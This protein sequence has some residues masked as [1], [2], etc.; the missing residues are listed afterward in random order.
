VSGKSKIHIVT[1]GCPKNQVDSEVLQAQLQL[2]SGNVEV[3]GDTDNADTIVINTCGFIQDAKRESIDAI[4]EAIEKKKHGEV[5]KIIVMGCLAERFKKELAKELP[6]VDSFF[7]TRQMPEILSDLDV[8]YKRELIG[9]RILSTPSH[10]AYLKISE[11]CDNPCSFCAIPLMRG[12]HLSTPIEELV[13]ETRL[14]AA[15]GV[16]ELVVIGQDSTYYGLD[17]YGERRLA[18]LL[19]ELQAVDGIEWIRLM[20]AYPAKFPLDVLQA[21]QRYSKLCR[22]IDMPVQHIADNVLKSMRRGITQRA[23]KEL[24]W[25]VKKEIPDI[26]L[27]TTLIVGYPTETED[28]FKQLCEFVQEMKFHRLGVFMYSQEEGTGAYEL[29]DPIPE[30]VKQERQEVL[31]EIQ[32]QISEERNESLVGKT[33]NVLIDSYDGEHYIGRTEWDA[34]EVD[35]EVLVHSDRALIPGQIISATVTDATEYDLFADA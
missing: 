25:T 4:V 13:H 19:G 32:K 2:Q 35:Q 24:L 8:N 33:L 10:T 3:V 28:D 20:Y 15:K 17:L 9:E 1:L 31:M 5:K 16:K 23:T 12:Q 6:E 34:P 18:S 26:A 21:F 27:R 11:G 14:L 7:G 30:K 29:G 22:Y